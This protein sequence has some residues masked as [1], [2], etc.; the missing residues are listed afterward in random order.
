[1][2]SILVLSGSPSAGSR[3]AALADHVAT[4]LRADGHTVDSVRVRDLPAEPLSLADTTHPAIT[5]VVSAVTAAHGVVVASPVFKLAYSGLLKLLLDLL[6]QFALADKVVLPVVT[7]GSP[8]HVLAID[9]ALRPVLSRSA[10]TTSCPAGSC[11][12]G[13]S[14]RWTA[15]SALTGPPR[16]RSTRS[17]TGSL[18]PSARGPPGCWKR[19]HDVVVQGTGRRGPAGTSPRMVIRCMTRCASP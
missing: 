17:S 10:P 3:T 5:A 13:T 4:R 6:P 1:M 7:G 14:S 12:T 16:P 2:S 9:Y 11:W 15:T 18:P 19:C 8:A